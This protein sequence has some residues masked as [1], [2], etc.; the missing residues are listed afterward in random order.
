MPQWQRYGKCCTA[1]WFRADG[2]AAIVH[3]DDPLGN[4]KAKS[5]TTNTL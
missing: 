4:G 5:G 2:D 3:V 1:I